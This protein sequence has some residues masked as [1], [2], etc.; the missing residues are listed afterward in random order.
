MDNFKKCMWCCILSLGDICITNIYETRRIL[1]TE[2]MRDRI[3]SPEELS[4]FLTTFPSRQED[5]CG[6]F[7]IL[8]HS[9]SGYQTGETSPFPPPTSPHIYTLYTALEKS[10]SMG[11]KN[12]WWIGIEQD[13]S[14]QEN[15][16][17]KILSNGWPDAWVS[18]IQS[19]KGLC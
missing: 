10:P 19:N 6:S 3:W 17:R 4:G 13:I 9:E 16:N 5:Q 14:S 12:R 2:I 7:R 15:R 1:M 11:T 8:L 18:P